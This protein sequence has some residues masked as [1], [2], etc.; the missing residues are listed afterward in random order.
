MSS[1]TTNNNMCIHT[2]L[3]FIK[4]SV[5]YVAKQK[6]ICPQCTLYCKYFE[7]TFQ[8]QLSKGPRLE[9]RCTSKIHVHS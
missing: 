9:E 2:N 1:S 8:F 7:K 3:V 6:P 5:E 4:T